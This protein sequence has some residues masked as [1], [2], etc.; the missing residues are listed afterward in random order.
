M[1]TQLFPKLCK[2]LDMHKHFTEHE[3]KLIKRHFKMHQIERITR[4]HRSTIYRIV[5]GSRSNKTEL[6]QRVLR[7]CNDLLTEALYHENSL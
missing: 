2:N 5:T 6:G 3:W 4:C 1:E 7:V